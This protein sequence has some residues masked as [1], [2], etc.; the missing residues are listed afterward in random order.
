MPYTPQT[1]RVL[2]ELAELNPTTLAVMHGSSFSGDGAGALR[3]YSQVLRE[4][5]GSP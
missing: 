5:F 1:D 2:N 4:V 3:D